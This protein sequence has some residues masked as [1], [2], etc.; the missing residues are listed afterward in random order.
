MLLKEIS[1][2][3]GVG[4]SI[5]ATVATYGFFSWLDRNAS[6]QA[7]K[8]VSDWLRR[9]PYRSIDL[10]Q[11]I[12]SAF[13]NLYSFPLLRIKAFV[14]SAVVSLGVMILLFLLQ[15][16]VLPLTNFN[17]FFV[18]PV[19]DVIVEQSV[20]IISVILSDY[21][22]LFVV[23]PSLS[24]AGEH[25]LR[26]LLAAMFGGFLVILAF[27]FVLWFGAMGILGLIRHSVILSVHTTIKVL[28][29]LVSEDLRSMI[30]IN[31]P[32]L[33]VHLW[34]PLFAAGAI[35]VRLL[36]TVF[37]AIE[38]AQWFLKQ[39]DRHPFRA[40]GF[41]AAALVFGSIAIVKALAIS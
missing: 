31:S 7:T 35:G 12:E 20:L 3:L 13:D 4:G 30:L 1:E 19:Y 34:L 27:N 14:R 37:Q 24:L 9:Q 21:V 11:A 40:I 5:I 28:A 8:A 38:G 23:R 10:K 18:V 25:L 15:F 22:S 29:K 39:G 6:E 32:A 26:G 16:I 33:V 41:V 2:A 36:F 17:I